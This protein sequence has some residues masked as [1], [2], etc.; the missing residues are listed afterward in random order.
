LLSNFWGRFFV[1]G[2]DRHSAFL[3]NVTGDDD[4]GDEDACL[5]ARLRDVTS[6]S[7][8]LLLLLLLL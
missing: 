2:V 5:P 4:E 1:N 3:A 6:R 7:L 8:L